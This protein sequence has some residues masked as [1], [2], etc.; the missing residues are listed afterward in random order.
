MVTIA[1][2]KEATAV[3]MAGTTWAVEDEGHKATMRDAVA[4]MYDFITQI[5]AATVRK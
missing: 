4:V 2:A 1:E 3:I 5:E